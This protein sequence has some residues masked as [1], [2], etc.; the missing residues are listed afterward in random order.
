MMRILPIV[1]LCIL[2]SPTAYGQCQNCGDPSNSISYNGDGTFSATDAQAYYWE[3]C[4]GDASIMGSNTDQKVAVSC[5]NG[6][7]QLKLVRFTNGSCVETCVS[8]ECENGM[9][10]EGGGSEGG[11]GMGSS[12]D[13]PSVDDIIFSNEAGNG[14]CATGMATIENLENIKSIKWTWALAGHT[15]TVVTTGNTA[16]FYYPPGNWTNYYMAVCAEVTLE[17][18]T[19]CIKKCN[20]FLLDCGGNGGNNAK[21]IMY[22]N[23]AKTQL[24]IQSNNQNSKIAQVNIHNSYGVLVQSI[25]NPDMEN[26]IHLLEKGNGIYFVTVHFGDGSTESKKLVINN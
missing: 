8:H 20:S 1:L 15:G 9:I 14:L 23:P 6:V 22:P 2:F 19:D 10:G 3:I 4:S 12:G 18:G 17:N 16:S 26:P 5:G 21:S 25:G 24:T 13:C 11:G 7:F